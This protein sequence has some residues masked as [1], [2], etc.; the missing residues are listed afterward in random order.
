LRCNQDPVFLRYF[1][2]D[3]HIL[4]GPLYSLT[5]AAAT[6][7][8]EETPLIEPLEHVY[9]CQGRNADGVWSKF[10]EMGTLDQPVPLQLGAQESQWQVCRTVA[11]LLCGRVFI[12]GV[13]IGVLVGVDED[14]ELL[15]QIIDELLQPNNH[16]KALQ[17]VLRGIWSTEESLEN[18]GTP[19]Y[20]NHSSS[21]QNIWQRLSGRVIHREITRTNSDGQQYHVELGRCLSQLVYLY[22]AN[23]LDQRQLVV[24]EAEREAILDEYFSESGSD[25]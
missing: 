20:E 21:A 22:W 13:F 4:D 17:K 5:L 10:V 25:G 3:E 14:E 6:F 12:P 9:R 7:T 19:L 1:S 16:E 2:V 23:T 11:G 18:S 24:M 8:F 15:K